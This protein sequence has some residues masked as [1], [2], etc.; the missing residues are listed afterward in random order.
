MGPHSADVEVADLRFAAG[1]TVVL[2][3]PAKRFVDVALAVLL[4][5]CVA[6]LFP[7]FFFRIRSDGGPCFYRHQRLGLNGQTFGCLKFRTMVPDADKVLADLLAR[8]P[9]AMTEWERT[10]KLA[11]DPRVT[12]IGRFLRKTSLD[13]LPQL[14]NVLKGEMSLVGPRPITQAE[15]A[16]YGAAIGSYYAVRPGITGLWQISG[17][18]SASYDQRVALDAEYVATASTVRDV[19]IMLKTVPAVLFCRGAC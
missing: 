11:Q 13:E 2:Q 14:I 16:R 1:E 7:I 4:L 17:R 19:W 10:Q 6:P 15:V 8:D 18:S 3:R 5:V 9:R 12:S